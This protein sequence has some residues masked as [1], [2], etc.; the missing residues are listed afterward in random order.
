MH[1][2]DAARPYVTMADVY[3]AWMAH[4]QVPYDDWARHIREKIATYLPDA[5]TLTDLGCGTGHLLDRLRRSGLYVRGIDA[6]DGMIEKARERLPADIVLS[7]RRLPH[8]TLE[9]VGPADV[10]TACF[11][12][13]NY[14][15]EPGDFE[16]TV[17]L[18]AESLKSGGIFFFDLNT[19]F[20]LEQIFA[21]YNTG[22]D[23]GDF[24][25]VWRNRYDPD[26]E[27]LTAHVTFFVRS[28]GQEFRR[29]TEVHRERWFTPDHVRSVLEKNALTVRGVWDGYTDQP[30]TA[31]TLRETWLAIKQ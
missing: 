20:K 8:V 12:V 29:A 31:N 2:H 6:S 28:G 10:V 1:E 26:T 18:V 24:A 23:A 11:D 9:D 4:D 14:L 19:R 30:A 7:V 15:V 22:D 25:Y 5:M 16:S 17:K 21:S 13:L 27:M 3:D